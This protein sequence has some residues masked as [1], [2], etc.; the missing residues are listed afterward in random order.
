[1]QN[2]AQVIDRN[3][4]PAK[5]SVLSVENLPRVEAGHKTA[6]NAIFRCRP[7]AYDNLFLSLIHI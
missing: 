6:F 2:T 7:T 5:K 3:Q 4:Q 1:M